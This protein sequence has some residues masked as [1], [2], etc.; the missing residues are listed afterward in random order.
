MANKNNISSELKK[1]ILEIV[2]GIVLAIIAGYLADLIINTFLPQYKSFEGYIHD[3]VTAV[4]I[5]I[6][7]MLITGS[8]IKLIEFKLRKS[9]KEL[10]G[11]SLIIR[12]VFY[13]IILALVLAAFHISITGILAGSA[14]GGIVL[15]LAIQTVASNLVASL[16]VTSTGTIKYGDVV[17]INSWEWSID[18]TGKIIDIKTLFSKMLTKDNTVIHIPN[19]ALL[20]NSVM[21][22]YRTDKD[23]Y[24]YPLTEI[25]NADVPAEMVMETFRSM[26]GDSLAEIY[27]DSKNGGTNTYKIKIYFSEV[28]ELNGKVS[29]A[30]LMLDHAYWSV[31]SNMNVLGNNGLF[32]D[33]I[34]YEYTPVSV[35][36][37]S[38]VPSSDII[39]YSMKNPEN[40][41]LKIFLSS[42][43]GSSSVYTVIA[44]SNSISNRTELI[45][46]VNLYMEK[47]YD[48]LKNSTGKQ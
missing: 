43:T 14:I 22:E 23:R 13:I 33:K 16:F 11:I 39:E 8:A 7:G 9:R 4:I 2:I 40:M 36:L 48:K 24:V 32:E 12:I 29:E 28:D 21:T 6:V 25:A 34:D 27:L 47:V 38:D 37:N 17:G 3:G 45:S 26:A 31:K 1:I 41:E 20:G 18:T 15:G 44:R 10:F 46:N 30:N 35:T 42:K 5:L 19:S